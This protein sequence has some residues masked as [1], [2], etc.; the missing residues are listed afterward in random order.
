M[1]R[2]RSGGGHWRTACAR[3]SSRK[4]WPDKFRW[5]APSGEARVGERTRNCCCKHCF[6]GGSIAATSC[7]RKESAQESRRD[8]D[9]KQEA[10]DTNA[11]KRGDVATG[12][13]GLD[14]CSAWLANRRPI[15]NAAIDQRARRPA[16]ELRL[17]GAI[18]RPSTR[19]T[20]R[21]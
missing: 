6:Q 3:S 18:Q 20:Y 15:D 10:L 4:H 19:A 9:R 11:F 21:R 8:K 17:P 12:F 13:G 7:G 2:S 14:G 1:G 5:P 16:F